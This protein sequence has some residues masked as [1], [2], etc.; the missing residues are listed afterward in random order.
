M[1]LNIEKSGE[2]EYK[3]CSRE[4]LVN[5]DPDFG[6]TLSEKD[7]SISFPPPPTHTHTHPK[8]N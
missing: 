1:L 8:K 2:Q 6:S 5:I 4:W 7:T 3:E